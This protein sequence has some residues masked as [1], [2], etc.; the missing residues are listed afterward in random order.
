MKWKIGIAL[1]MNHILEILE[2]DCYVS[3]VKLD[4]V[5]YGQKQAPRQLY[6]HHSHLSWIFFY[7]LLSCSPC[8]DNAKEKF[9][10]KTS[11]FKIF[12]D[13]WIKCSRTLQSL[14]NNHSLETLDL[15]WCD[16]V[17]D[18]IVLAIMDVLLKCHLETQIWATLLW[19]ERAS[20]WSW[21]NN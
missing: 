17:K 21:A 5:D 12:S 4:L 3:S 18:T 9:F 16:G 20:M 6:T 14:V 19:K 11:W 10:D 1:V 7:E 2:L 8:M 13:K 15:G